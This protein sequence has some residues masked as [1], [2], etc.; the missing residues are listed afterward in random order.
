MQPVQDKNFIHSAITTAVLFFRQAIEP[1]DRHDGHY[2]AP[3]REIVPMPD[4]F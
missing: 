4:R 3:R 2:P 1:A